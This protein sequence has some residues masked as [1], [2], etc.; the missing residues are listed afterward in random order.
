LSTEW[1]LMCLCYLGMDNQCGLNQRRDSPMSNHEGFSIIELLIVVAIILVIAAIAIPNLLRARMAANESSA[2]ASLRAIASAE[3]TYFNSYPTIGYANLLP[4]L[5]GPA[6]C[7]PAPASGCLLD[8][9]LSTATPGSTGK[10]GYQF[11]ATGINSAGTNSNYVAG[12]TPLA[13]GT[14]GN[15]NFCS[16]SEQILR[17]QNTPGGLPVTTLAACYAYPVAP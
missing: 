8:T 16:T 15:R 4:D 2:A 6:P 17:A 10:S 5:G 11:Q 3:I 12:G 9:S 14:S 13:P 1:P 7:T